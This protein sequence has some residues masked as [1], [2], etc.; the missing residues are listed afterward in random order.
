MR[1]E[2]RVDALIR[3]L[4]DSAMGGKTVPLFAKGAKGAR[5]AL[6]YVARGGRLGMLVDQK[7]N[8]GL[9]V[10]FFGQP[11]MTAPALLPWPCATA[12]RL[13]RVM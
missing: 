3:T 5:E 13:F 1:Q 2:T 7:M 6:A 4:R 10:T 11:A 8:D 9:E 12:V